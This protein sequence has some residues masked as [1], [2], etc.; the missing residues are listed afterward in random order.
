MN[1]NDKNFY[2][3]LSDIHMHTHLC[4]HA[5]GEP[6][7]SARRAVELG[8]AEIGISEH[9]PMPSRF[10]QLRMQE[11][12]FGRYLEMVE[13]ARRAFPNLRILLGVEAE[14]IAGQ[15]D[16]IRRFLGRA[17]WDYVIG[18]VHYIGDWNFDAPEAVAVWKKADLLEQ[19]RLYFEL[20]KKAAAT[21]LY[22]TLGHPDL[23]KKFGFV[24][25][26]PCEDL[27]RDALAEVARR[28]L[29]IE[30]NTAGLRKPVKEIYPS[31]TFLR[32]AREMNIPIT[33]G[34][35]AH[36]PGEVGMNFREAVALARACGYT[37]FAR[38]SKRQR[39]LHPLP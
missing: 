3:A 39:T 29:A 23:V 38:F 4:R 31:A 9:C 13:A 24:P 33:L 32:I 26:T 18:S 2:A 8:L 15:E 14:Y 36:A 25:R 34:S 27:F 21:G 1:A 17:N 35:D 12:D 28:G 30:I 11:K 10:D 5:K 19:W 37:E 7:D 20:W 16:E 6:V 22:D